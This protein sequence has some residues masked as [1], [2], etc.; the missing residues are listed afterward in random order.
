MSSDS[1]DDKPLVKGKFLLTFI[2]CLL[3]L[4]P[5]GA[6]L[7]VP[8]FTIVGLGQKS[9]NRSAPTTLASLLRAIRVLSSLPN[10]LSFPLTLSIAKILNFILTFLSSFH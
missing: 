5:Q 4:S 2:L 7:R 10:I 9:E 1:E 8:D 3:L 6:K